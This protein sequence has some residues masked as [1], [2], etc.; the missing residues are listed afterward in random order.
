MIGWLMDNEWERK[1]KEA[2]VAEYKELSRHLL[3]KTEGSHETRIV[4]PRAEIWVLNVSNTK[5]KFCPFDQR[6]SQFV[7]FPVS[8]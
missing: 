7:V 6:A 5:Q 4:G 1:W 3:G 2:V 8:H